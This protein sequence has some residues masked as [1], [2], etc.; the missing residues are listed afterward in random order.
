MT[1]LARFMDGRSEHSPMLRPLTFALA[2][3]VLVSG[4]SGDSLAGEE[5]PD[6][7][8]D[9]VRGEQVSLSD[10]RGQVVVVDFMSSM[11][12]YCYANG[13]VL[14]TLLRQHPDAVVVSVNFGETATS[15]LTRPGA[16]VNDYMET[17]GVDS[18][19]HPNWYFGTEVVDASKDELAD[20]YRVRST[21][22]LFLVAPDGTVVERQGGVIGE[23]YGERLEEL[24]GGEG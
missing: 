21:P 16:S 3:L 15:R 1:D 10:F 12:G 7:T 13:R 19:S 9:T 11:C 8:V 14:K 22:V 4:C 6:F 23:K 2:A 18:E 20:R 17:V 24:S 5:A